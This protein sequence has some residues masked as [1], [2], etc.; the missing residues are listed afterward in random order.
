MM[1]ITNKDGRC[2]VTFENEH[3]DKI[4]VHIT[5]SEVTDVHVSDNKL[6]ITIDKGT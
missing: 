5:N 6:I 2:W 4:Q 1:K 3:G